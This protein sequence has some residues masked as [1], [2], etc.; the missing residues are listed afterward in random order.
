M[1][2]K[3]NKLV[4]LMVLMLVCCQAPDIPKQYRLGVSQIESSPYGSWIDITLHYSDTIKDLQRIKGELIAIHS[5]TIFILSIFGNLTGV[6]FSQVKSAELLKYKNMAG[7]LAWI[8]LGF[9]LPSILGLMVTGIPG[10]L[11][12]GVP[13]LI[14]GVIFTIIEAASSKNML[15]YPTK[16]ELTDFKIYARFP[17]GIPPIVDRD[18]LYFVKGDVPQ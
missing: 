7:T 3:I 14:I 2:K 6:V 9:Y 5:D 16:N 12:L 1:L 17:Q 4:F 15:L 18:D 10:F 8:T 13:G 11:I